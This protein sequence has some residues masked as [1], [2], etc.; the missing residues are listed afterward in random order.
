MLATRCT[1]LTWGVQYW[2]QISVF[3]KMQQDESIQPNQ[4]PDH[5]IKILFNAKEAHQY[6]LDKLRKENDKS[7]K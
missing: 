4:F 3:Y 6:N 1:E 5:E 2:H 7:G